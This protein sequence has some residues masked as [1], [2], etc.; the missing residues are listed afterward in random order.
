MHT[1][2]DSVQDGARTTDNLETETGALGV[3]VANLADAVATSTLAVQELA[4][5]IDVIREKLDGVA[6]R[7]TR[8]NADNMARPFQRHSLPFLVNTTTNL[9]IDDLEM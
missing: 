6:G 2:Y 7:P 5:K 8:T 9:S 1:P 3:E 4:T